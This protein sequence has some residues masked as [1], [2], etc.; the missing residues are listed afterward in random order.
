[1]TKY[2]SVEEFRQEIIKKHETL[3]KRL[4]QVSRYILDHPNDVAIETLAVV[5]ERC[6]GQASTIVRFAKAFGFDSAS[7]MQRLFRDELVSGAGNLD[8]GE[9]IKHSSAKKPSDHNDPFHL[10]ADFTES[11]RRSLENLN[12]NINQANLQEAITLI[13]KANTIYIVGFKRSFPVAVYLAYALQK[14]NKR[15]ILV[16]NVG[17]LTKGQT[18]GITSDDLMIAI[19]YHP[20]TEETLDIVSDAAEHTDNI[21]A[22][23]DSPI[24]PIAAPAKVS[25][26]VK[27]AEVRQFRSL[28]ASLCLAQVLVIGHAYQSQKNSLYPES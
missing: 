28:S 18:V 23:T 9:R 20:Y 2:S 11:N 14:T 22:I 1:M 4:K 7:Q 24:S 12:A 19:S 16:D 6:G 17:G 13:T 27:E 26:E 5:A 25:F 10:M 15:C 3:S 21:I 8:Y